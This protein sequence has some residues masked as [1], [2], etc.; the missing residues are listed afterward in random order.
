MV[1]WYRNRNVS[2][3]FLSLF[4]YFFIIIH[5]PLFSAFA[6][7]SSHCLGLFLFYWKNFLLL[8][9]LFKLH[10]FLWSFVS[11][12]YINSFEL[13]FILW[14]N[15]HY[16]SPGIGAKKK[17]T[18]FRFSSCDYVLVADRSA[19]TSRRHVHYNLLPMWYYY[20]ENN[21]V[22]SE[23]RRGNPRDACSLRNHSLARRHFSLPLHFSLLESLFPPLKSTR[24]S[25]FSLSCFL[26][27]Y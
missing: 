7:N 4:L 12:T 27:V 13:M 2:S 5:L 6:K 25:V 3:P 1:Q 16:R 14:M 24:V 10:T 11:D 18:N 22:G 15:V 8:F 17:G 21:S 19:A 20:S 26:F 9:Y 23:C